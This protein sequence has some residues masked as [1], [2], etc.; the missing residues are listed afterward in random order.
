MAKFRKK[1]VVI[2]AEPIEILMYKAAND[3]WSMPEW[4]VTAYEKGDLLF[5]PEGIHINTLEGNMLG[6]PKDWLLKGISGEI[7]PC[8][9][10]IFEKTYEVV[11]NES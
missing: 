8:K 5:T 4:V 3:F 2:E 10:D 6:G 11:E 1:P 7:Y 9:S